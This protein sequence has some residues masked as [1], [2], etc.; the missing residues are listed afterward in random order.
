[1]P[2]PRTMFEKIFEMHTIRTR[3]EGEAL[4]YVDCNVVHEGPFYA[5]DDFEND[6]YRRLPWLRNAN[7][8]A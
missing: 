2:A 1:M 3:G 4:L 6:Y 5:F 8:D 7:H